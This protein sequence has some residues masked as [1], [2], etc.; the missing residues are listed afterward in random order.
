VLQSEMLIL[1]TVVLFPEGLNNVQGA[2]LYSDLKVSLYVEKL[3]E[4]LPLN[5][6]VPYTG[7]TA[8]F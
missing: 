8:Q 7:K 2:F 3:L 1:C 4:I 6:I 5:C